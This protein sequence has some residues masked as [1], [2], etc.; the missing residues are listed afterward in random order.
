MNPKIPKHL[1]G[2]FL[3]VG[4]YVELETDDSSLVNKIFNDATEMAQAVDEDNSDVISLNYQEMK[5]LL[6][7]S[8]HL[9]KG[10]YSINLDKMIAWAYDSDKDIHYFY[11]P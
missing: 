4:N 5:A 3:Y 1:I 8:V 7:S 9:F 11:K 2:Q 10:D 6:A